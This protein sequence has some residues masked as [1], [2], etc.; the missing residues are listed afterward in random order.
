MKIVDD[1][2]TKIVNDNYVSIDGAAQIAKV[3]RTT[4]ENWI[5]RG[6]GGKLLELTYL[7]GKPVVRRVDLEAFMI[8]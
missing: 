5:K 2:I 8:D 1:R 3:T 7:L 4:V 6:K